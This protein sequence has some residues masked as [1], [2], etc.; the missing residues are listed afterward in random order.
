M[1]SVARAAVAATPP[2]WLRGR[3]SNVVDALRRNVHARE[4]NRLRA[5]GFS[6]L[7]TIRALRQTR[8]DELAATKLLCRE[9]R[10]RLQARATPVGAA[11]VGAAPFK[12]TPV[13]A[14]PVGA[15]SLGAAPAARPHVAAV[16]GKSERR[17]R[18]LQRLC[19]AGA[20]G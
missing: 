1:L 10:L 8:Y 13:G 12:A 9:N 19:E 2:E 18:A 3:S 14:A 11:P 17:R 4:I 6:D 15:A 5:I 16:P 7:D 20:A